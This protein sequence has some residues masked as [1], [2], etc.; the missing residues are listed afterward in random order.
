MQSY[1]N[2]V[3][4]QILLDLTIFHMKPQAD[5]QKSVSDIWLKGDNHDNVHGHRL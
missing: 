4:V 3:T 1:N 5:R 2:R